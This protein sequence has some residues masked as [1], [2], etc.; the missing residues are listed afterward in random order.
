MYLREF[1]LDAFK[2]LAVVE[3][4]PVGK[5]SSLDAYLGG[6]DIGSGFYFSKYFWKGHDIAVMPLE[7]T[8]FACPDAHIREI[9]IPVNHIS[10]I[11]ADCLFAEFI[12]KGEKKRGFVIQGECILMCAFSC[13]GYTLQIVLDAA[14]FLGDL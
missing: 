6:I 14:Q 7:C 4:I 11:L 13:L 12:G 5:K 10:D 2:D 3:N 9:D 8:E 1:L